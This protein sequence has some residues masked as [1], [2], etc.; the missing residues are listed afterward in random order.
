MKKGKRFWEQCQL[1]T[2]IVEMNHE[3]VETFQT[4]RS[5]ANLINFIIYPRIGQLR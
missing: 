3:S 4:G 5:L 2:T 1:D